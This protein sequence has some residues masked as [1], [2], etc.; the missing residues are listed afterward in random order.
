MKT[1]DF[2]LDATKDALKIDSDR[3]LSRQLGYDYS[4]VNKFRKGKIYPSETAM[5]LMAKHADIDAK[6]ALLD[7]NIWRSPDE[8]KPIY[9][10]LAEMAF[11]V[12]LGI[13]LTVS[14]PSTSHASSWFSKENRQP[15]TL[16][17]IL[18]TFNISDYKL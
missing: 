17:E 8:A 15:S 2:Y 9:K 10:K 11:L 18:K 12:C 4:Y 6:Q 3:E 1:V 13:F 14:L 5:L 7:L 16:I